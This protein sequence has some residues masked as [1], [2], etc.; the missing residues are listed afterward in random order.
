METSFFDNLLKIILVKVE[1]AIYFHRVSV[2]CFVGQLPDGR[3]SS[4]IRSFLDYLFQWFLF[5]PT[6]HRGCRKA[7]PA[8]TELNLNLTLGH[9][10]NKIIFIGHYCTIFLCNNSEFEIN[11]LI[12]DCILRFLKKK[13]SF[14]NSKNSSSFI[15]TA[16]AKTRDWI[17]ILE[18]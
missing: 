2:F 7:S 16:L 5:K 18:L 3:Q 6:H 9:N 14:P 11:L 10:K 17:T 13:V 4:Q 12:R 8:P 1:G 15:L